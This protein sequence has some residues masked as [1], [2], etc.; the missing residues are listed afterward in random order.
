MFYL[1]LKRKASEMEAFLFVDVYLLMLI[2]VV[3]MKLLNFGTS[4]F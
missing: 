3:G 4:C 1:G 2:F